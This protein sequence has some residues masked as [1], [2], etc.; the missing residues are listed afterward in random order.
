MQQVVWKPLQWLEDEL[1]KYS[2][3]FYSSF[4][5]TSYNHKLC[6]QAVFELFS[7]TFLQNQHYWVTTLFPAVPKKMKLD[8]VF[9]KDVIRALKR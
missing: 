3:P 2:V 4:F 6:W 9:V 7:P 8:Q 1:N 5:S